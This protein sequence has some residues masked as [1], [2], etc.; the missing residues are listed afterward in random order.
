MKGSFLERFDEAHGKQYNE[1]GFDQQLLDRAPIHRLVG[2]RRLHPAIHS[3]SRR[4][5]FENS[6]LNHLADWR[7]FRDAT[8]V[9]ES[10]EGIVL[11]IDGRQAMLRNTAANVW[12]LTMYSTSDFDWSAL[13]TLNNNP[14]EV[15]KLLTRSFQFREAQPGEIAS[16]LPMLK[17]TS[18]TL[19]LSGTLVDGIPIIERPEQFSC[20]LHLVNSDVMATNEYNHLRS[21]DNVQE[22]KV[23]ASTVTGVNLSTVFM[24]ADKKHCLVQVQI[25]HGEQR[26]SSDYLDVKPYLNS[27]A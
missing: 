17:L 8:F 27:Q 15:K 23:N 11:T 6:I 2:E 19:D 9:S 3:A 14:E 5:Y 21:V 12:E 1:Y 24:Q 22:M 7:F 25:H 10:D 20:T 16:I 13:A 18:G 26:V 4:V